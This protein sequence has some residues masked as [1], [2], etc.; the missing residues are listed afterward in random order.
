MTDPHAPAA[1][2]TGGASGIGL[3]LVRALGERGLHVVVAD[4]DADAAGRAAAVVR[5]TG[6]QAEPR[7]V[8]VARRGQLDDLVH[9]IG[10]VRPL[11]YVFNNAGVGGTLAFDRATPQHWDRILD[12]NL[13]S[14]IEGTSAAY[15]V[16]AEQGHGHIVN[17]ASV[18][19]LVPVPLQTLYN[20]TKAAVV[21][22]S[23]SLR[24]EA[25]ARG[26]RVSVVCPGNVATNIFARPI[27]GEPTTTPTVPTDAIPADEAA[28]DILRGVDRDDEVIVFPEVARRL[29]DLHDH[30]R[31]GWTRWAGAEFRRRSGTGLR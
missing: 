10:S 7:T 11:D 25:A 5:D 19:G 16:M 14:V 26:I 13:R 8:D 12:L 23:R 1:L 3:A 27:L 21:A 28:D 30:D 18:S 24:P 15:A 31:A 4:L 2:V 17:T 20:T 22:L 9:E 6:G 29:V